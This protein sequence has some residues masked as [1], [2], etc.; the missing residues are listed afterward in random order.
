MTYMQVDHLDMAVDG[1]TCVV[2]DL[3]LWDVDAGLTYFEQDIVDALE[4]TVKKVLND[5]LKSET[6]FPAQGSGGLC[7]E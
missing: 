7:S 5:V 3:G 4:P 1:L 6:P 2:D